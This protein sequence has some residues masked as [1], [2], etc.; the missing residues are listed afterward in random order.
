MSKKIRNII[1]AAAAVAAFAVPALAESTNCMVTAPEIRLRKS[2]S[3]K[4]KV[5]AVLKKDARV[6]AES[7]SGGWVKVSSADGKLN[8]YVGGWALASSAPVMVASTEP[9]PIP[10]SA[11][12]AAEAAKE[13]PSNEKL[14]MQITDLRLKVLNVERDVAMMRKDIRK[15]KV[16]M[17]HKK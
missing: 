12:P 1:L 10:S 2:A 16:A 17:K 3:K 5:V 4:A 13:V 15:I 14:A 11:A 7:C 6:T 8:G 9:V